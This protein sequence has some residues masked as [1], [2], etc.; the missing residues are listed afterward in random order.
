MVVKGHYLG[1]TLAVPLIDYVSSGRF[2]NPSTPQFSHLRIRAGMEFT[3]TQVCSKDFTRFNTCNYCGS[4][5]LL[6]RQL[7]CFIYEAQE[8]K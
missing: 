8:V 3:M 1:L 4:P 2:L 7:C 5:I 6:I